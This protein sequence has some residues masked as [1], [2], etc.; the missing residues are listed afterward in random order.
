MKNTLLVLALVA[1]F[2]AFAVA[3]A[4]DSLVMKDGKKN[5]GKIE[6]F[7]FRVVK[8]SVK[9]GATASYKVEDIETVDFGGLPKEFKDAETAMR[10]G[11]NDDAATKFAAV[12]AGKFRD[13][14]KQEAFWNQANCLLDAGKGE[15]AAKAFQEM[16][17]K[18]P[19]SRYLEK[20]HEAVVRALVSAGKAADAVT[21]TTSEEERVTKIPDSR[22]L[23]DGLKLYR[24]QAQMKAGQGA[25]AKADLQ[26]LANTGGPKAALARVMLGQVL[27]A[28]KSFPDAEKCFR[29]SLKDCK[30]TAVKAVAY[31]GLGEI[32]YSQGL[33]AKKGEVIKDA[34]MSY[35]RTVVQ[36][37][38][39]P[40]DSTDAYE[41]A[42]LG[43]GKCFQSLG[44]LEKPGDAQKVFFARSRELL[45]RL[46]NEYR[47][48]SY[49]D[50][51]KK[52]LDTLGG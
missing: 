6:S 39:A 37:P 48:S 44:Q 20:A 5:T 47:T 28:E 52:A 1:G 2:S 40:G 15:E 50:E 36:F 16:L 10:A 31:N 8:L 43:A 32:L 41:R 49:T 26:T 45:R 23:V 34:L 9:A 29:E 24:C 30:E 12:I 13:P 17:A 35:L 22:A 38:P 25:Q 21:W 3:Q 18:F 46:L 27:L 51:A 7:D 11:S 14:I 42:L 33:T 4:D 19:Q